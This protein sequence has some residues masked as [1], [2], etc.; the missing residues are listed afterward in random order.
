[1]PKEIKFE[2]NDAIG[3][4]TLDVIAKADKFNRWMYETIKPFCKGKTLEIGSGIGNISTFFL[5][6][7]F[8]M[9]LT[10]IRQNYFEKLN[11]N[12]NQ[13][14]NFLG[15]EVMN[16]TD[17]E[18]D[19]K[20]KNHLEQYDTVFA[21]NVVE[22][23][24]DDNLAIKNCKKLL[25]KDG[26]LVILVPSYQGLFNK[27]DTELGHYRRYTKSKL[28]KVFKTNS[29]KIIHKQH[30]NFIG[31]LGWY[32]TG[33]L[34]KKE[35]IPGGQMKLYNKLVPLFKVVDKVIFNSVGLSTIVVGK[36]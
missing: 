16:L 12:F 11:R 18:F 1:M 4:A 31:I 13:Y 29:F 21:L 3:E 2:E 25:K 32:V 10:D 15:S 7:G 35:S 20:F 24:K 36:K 6:D 34:M 19:K 30:F 23:I 17:V 26:H 28:A 22:H 5:E 9:V 8:E 27:F 14:S 33:S